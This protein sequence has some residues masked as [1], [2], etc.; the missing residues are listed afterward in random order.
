MFTSIQ[1]LNFW[2]FIWDVGFQSVKV[3]L[4]P[5]CFP[6]FFRGGCRTSLW[7]FE[8]VAKDNG[9]VVQEVVSCVI[10]INFT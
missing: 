9:L 4:V 2:M 8:I 1:Q 7:W 5:V 3:N 10:V 6:F